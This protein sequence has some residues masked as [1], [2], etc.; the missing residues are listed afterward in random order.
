V[1]V[2]IMFAKG[3]NYANYGGYLTAFKLLVTTSK[4]RQDVIV[5]NPNNADLV[6]VIDSHLMPRREFERCL[7]SN[8][9]VKHNLDRVF[10]YDETDNP[11][12][13]YRGLFVSMPRLLFKRTRHSSTVYWGLKDSSNQAFT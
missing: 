10:V 8:S 12:S 13:S 9:V 3:D 1:N 11:A 2:H 5:E 6:L 7:N 4:S